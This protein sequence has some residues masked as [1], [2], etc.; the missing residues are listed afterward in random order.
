MSAMVGVVVGVG[1]AVGVGGATK[2]REVW[3]VVVGGRATVAVADGGGAGIVA[4]SA[5]GE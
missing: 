1:E 3:G 4:S 2:E 5:A